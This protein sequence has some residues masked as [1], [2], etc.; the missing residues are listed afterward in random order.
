MALRKLV[1]MREALESDGYFGTLLVGDSWRA[2]RALLIAIAGE[3]LRDEE[4]VIFRSL[5]GR[6][7]EPLEPVAEFWAVIGRRGGKTRATAILGCYIAACCD[8]R[9]ALAPG[10]RGILPILAASTAQ[11]AT[12]FRFVSGAFATAPNLK[13]LVAGETS[14][15][16]SLT[17]GV[18]VEVRPASY[19]TIRGIS[20]VG[21]IADEIAYWRSDELSTNPDRE[22]LKALRPSL[23]TT[24]GLLACISSPHAKRGELFLTYKRHFGPEGHPAIL[25]AKAASRV[26]NPSL[27][28]KVIDR[29]YEED[30]DAALAE[31]G[32]EFRGDIEQFIT[33]EAIEACVTKG[34]SVRAP[35]SSERYHAFCDPSG[36]SADSMTMAICHRELKNG[37]VVLDYIG[38]R[39]APFS[40]DSVVHE[41]CAVLSSYRINTIKGDRYAGEWPRERFR[42]NGV[43][44]EP[45]EKP[46]SELYV[47]FL[48][49]VN[50]GRVDLLDNQ[51]MVGQFVGLERRTSRAGKDSIDHGPS[52]RDDVANSV[53]GCVV[54][55]GGIQRMFISDAALRAGKRAGPETYRRR[56]LLMEL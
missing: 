40:P 51:R 27:S 49:Y 3:E 55:T 9:G 26:M 12:A 32:A 31:Y 44:Y 17:T 45:S 50:S 47:E 15:T 28:Q 30:P 16:L 5:T 25:V 1:T 37:R 13:G 7:R 22:I 21:A 43:M 24:G 20:A 36:G 42:L 33:R 19:R 23:A 39:R 10:E 53:A 35:L 56:A 54:L 38:E 11:A 52:A 29:A 41:F 4:R 8:H 46:R 18:D 14:D 6:D 2:W 34:V 48:P